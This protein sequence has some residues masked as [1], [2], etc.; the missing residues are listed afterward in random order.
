M[1]KILTTSG[2]VAYCLSLLVSVDVILFHYVLNKMVCKM[3]CKT[4]HTLIVV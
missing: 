2:F 4:A 3:V 1:P